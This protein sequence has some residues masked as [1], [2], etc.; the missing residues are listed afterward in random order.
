METFDR[1]D[2]SFR[3]AYS[4]A[5]ELAMAEAKVPLSTPGTVQLEVRSGRQFYYRYYYDPS[6]KRRS[7]Y[8]GAAND[9]ATMARIETLQA[10]IVD[11]A[12]L[13]QYSHDLRKIGFY[14]ADNSTVVTVATL[15]NAGIFKSGGVLVGTHAFGV[16]LNDLGFRQRR[17]L[18]T[19]DVDVARARRLEIAALPEGGLLSLLNQ[20]GLQFFGMPQLRNSQPP[21]SFKARGQKLK[22]DLLVPTRGKPYQPIEIA[23]LGAYA[24]GLPHF[25]FLLE[26]PTPSMLIGRDRLVPVTIPH[27]GR[28]CIH[29]MIVYSLRPAG[30]SAKRDKDIQQA[31]LLA[32]LLAKTDDFLLEEAIHSLPPTSRARAKAGAAR[33][34]DLLPPEHHPEAT[35]LLAPLVVGK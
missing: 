21:T 30:D 27:P 31:A 24:T 1:F 29:K 32:N 16:I 4:Q 9:P 26:A 13:I 5:K 10:E 17:H 3:T 7:E 18:L 12:Q 14:C 22:V 33:V 20:S 28:L 23:E 19:E 11:Y 35:Q 15:A 25:S 34:L 2:L 8:L 6:G